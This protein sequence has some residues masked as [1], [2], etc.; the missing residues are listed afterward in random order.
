[1]QIINQINNDCGDD[2]KKLIDV[3]YS[4]DNDKICETIDSD[5]DCSDDFDEDD[6]LIICGEDM[7]LI[8]ECE[9]NNDDDDDDYYDSDPV[10]ITDD[11]DAFL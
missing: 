2:I 11:Y 10:D 7:E 8:K 1:M 5:N 6:D 4:Y 9:K 3:N